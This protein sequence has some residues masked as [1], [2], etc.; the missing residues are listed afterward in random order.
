MR[1]PQGPRK[2]ADGQSVKGLA[3]WPS[4]WLRRDNNV[5]QAARL[6]PDQ[7]PLQSAF[8]LL[9]LMMI[10]FHSISCFL[11]QRWPSSVLHLFYTL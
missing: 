1:A 8:Q 4:V 6:E 11:N 7:V 9:H 2:E 5:T 10:V 3:L